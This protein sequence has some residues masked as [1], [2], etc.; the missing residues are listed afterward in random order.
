MNKQKNT[1]KSNTIGNKIDSINAFLCLLFLF[2]KTTAQSNKNFLAHRH[3]I[4]KDAQYHYSLGKCK[5]NP[6]ISVA[7]IKD[8]KNFN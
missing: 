6:L 3:V 4:Y 8:T 2:Y 7:I 5:T 1:P